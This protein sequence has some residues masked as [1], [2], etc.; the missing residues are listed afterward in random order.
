MFL[1]AG[2][3]TPRPGV[4]DEVDESRVAD[5][6]EGLGEVEEEMVESEGDEGGVKG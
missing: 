4:D 6:V 2:F 3:R 1:C 5:G